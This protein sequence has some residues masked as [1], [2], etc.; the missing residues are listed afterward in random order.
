MQCPKCGNSNI[1]AGQ[2]FCT[3]CGQPLSAGSQS[4][5]QPAS[6]VGDKGFIDNLTHPGTFLSRGTQGVQA[7]VRRERL[8]RL[9][10][11]AQELGMDVSRPQNNNQTNVQQPQASEPQQRRLIVDTDS[12]EGVNIVSGRA[13]WNIQK[14]EI[15]RL[16]T[17]TEF[18]AADNLK[19]VIIQE[20]CM[21]MVYI[22]GQLVSMMPAGVYTFP[23]KTETEIRLERRQSEID[24]QQDE[25]ERQRRE[26]EKEED[27]K[28]RENAQSFASRGVFGEIA[29]FGRGVMNFLFGKK[30]NEKPEQRNTR[31]QRTVQKLK[32]LPAPK[33]CRVYIASNRIINML[34]GATMDAE[35]NF[36]F[37]PMTIPTKLVDVNIGVTMQLQISNMQQLVQN[38]LADRNRL[39]V[40]DI[41]QEL[42]PGVKA[43]LTQMLRNLDYQANGL[44]EPI[45]NNLKGR[46]QTACNERMQGIEVVRVLDITDQSSDFDRFRAVE[47]ELF[48]SEKE[49]GFLQRTN[50]FR[51]RLEQ[52]QN[53]RQ[54]DQ[55]QNVEQLRQS[56]QAINKDKLLSE[57]EME[58]FVALLESQKRIREANLQKDEVIAKE[59]IREALIDMKKSG[60]VKDDEL[61]ALENTLTQ[62]KISRENVTD[63][64]RVQAEQKLE[65]ERQIAEFSLSDSRLEHDMANALR[66][67]QH[68]GNLTAAQL[69]TKRLMDA[70]NDERNEF[71]WSRTFERQQKEDNYDFYQTARQDDYDFNKDQRQHHADFQN[72][73]QNEDYDWHKAQRE[74]LMRREDEDR[75]RI[76]ARQDKFDDMDIAER[77]AAIDHQKMQDLKD[78]QFREMQEMNRLAEAS[79]RSNEN[80]HSMD[81]QERMHHATMEQQ[82]TA[83]QL[84]ETH[85]ENLSEAAQVA[86]FNAEGAK[87]QADFFRKQQEEEAKRREEDRK[88]ALE[89]ADRAH[90]D[91]NA[92]MDRMERIQRNSSA[93]M[94][95]MM[96]EMM[97]T[98][99]DVSASNAQ[100]MSGQYQH[101][102][103]TLQQMN[104]LQQQHM[105]QR[106]D[107]QVAR[108]KEYREDAYH[109][110]SRMD[111]TQDQF[112]ANSTQINTAAAT[113]MSSS[114]Q[115]NDVNV[116]HNY[117]QP[118]NTP[119][120]SK[121]HYCPACG[122]EVPESEMF[123]G[124]CG[125]K[126]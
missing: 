114:A 37:A 26:L 52:E 107:D 42:Q 58:Q 94:K 46:L 89:D 59:E 14:G 2:K 5:A 73:V 6:N 33:I 30:K 20:G 47:R 121:A 10:Q 123:C 86:S 38:Y 32:M 12:V 97:G 34:F 102:M 117:A 118:R 68:Q 125:Q 75:A 113:N 88:R 81:V 18:A 82:M 64:M 54:I 15:A 49:L 31:M 25:L 16:I 41:Q 78:A 72:R 39:T 99:R 53:R 111:H 17:E 45:V 124:E 66:Q 43:L 63:I 90:A 106:Y 71:D 19:G 110:Q 93:D 112:M 27:E 100:A 109:Q 126:M 104:T 11:Q 65:M 101:Q 95:D 80:I 61:A 92:D 67:A 87:E 23:A 108:G 57:D 103:D 1:K 51:S 91:R 84:R 120:Q 9:Q 44:P 28:A 22:D 116:Q 8:Q 74:A 76:N 48:A 29:A 7:Q 105:Q 21:A 60:L 55:A 62:G 79:M 85:R 70:Y 35:G 77:Q 98:V 115:R 40:A 3:N 119:L 122:A 96:R 56:L 4:E 13:I 36:S 24:Q 50:E 83:E 69:D